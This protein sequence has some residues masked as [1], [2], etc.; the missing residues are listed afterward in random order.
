MGFYRTK[1]HLA[2]QQFRLVSANRNTTITELDVTQIH[3]KQP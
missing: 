2:E 1:L 3:N